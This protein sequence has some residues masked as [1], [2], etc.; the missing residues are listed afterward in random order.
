MYAPLAQ[1]DR[2]LVYGTKGQGFE[3]LVACQKE[4]EAIF[5]SFLL[6]C[7]AF[8]SYQSFKNISTRFFEEMRWS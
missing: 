2:A 4:K 1:L 8:D 6:S 7:L 5:A 3:S